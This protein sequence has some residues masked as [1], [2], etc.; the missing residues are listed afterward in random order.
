MNIMRY[1]P[2]SLS[3][4]DS[5]FSDA[6]SGLSPLSRFASFSDQ[7][8]NGPRGIAADLYEDDGHFYVRLEMPGAKRNE[9]KV[10]LDG[11]LLSI[12]FDKVVGGEGDG[13]SRTSYL[14]K[15]SVPVGCAA[16]KITAALKDGLLTVT[17]PK[18]E[19]RKPKTIEVS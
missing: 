2:R 6:L 7:P 13:E 10:E 17:M 3:G 1:S 11:D 8:L 16:A 12:S 14:R 4:F 5:L 15:M 18:A 9:I 19:E